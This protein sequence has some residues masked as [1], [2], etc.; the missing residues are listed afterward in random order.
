[1]EQS[2]VFVIFS[3]KFS[4]FILCP[5]PP[6]HLPCKAQ[7]CHLNDPVE[8]GGCSQAPLQSPPCSKLNKLG[9]ICLPSHGKCSSCHHLRGI[10]L[11]PSSTTNL[12]ISLLHR[13][14]QNW[15]QCNWMQPNKCWVKG[16]IP[17]LYLPAVLL[18]ILPRMLLPI[19][20]VRA[21]CWPTLNSLPTRPDDD[22]YS[23]TSTGVYIYPHHEV[24]ILWVWPIPP[25]YPGPSEGQHRPPAYP[26]SL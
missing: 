21:L 24:S 26:K 10:P 19:F 20:A 25:D 2:P 23:I 3:P 11:T 9:S 5:L 17:S 18:T 1:M 14:A 8:T 15:T 4:F 22:D 13:K 7:L 12:L 16:I 6:V